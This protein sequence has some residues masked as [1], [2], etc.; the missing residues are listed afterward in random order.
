MQT[1]RMHAKAVFFFFLHFMCFIKTQTDCDKVFI[2]EKITIRTH[3]WKNNETSVTQKKNDFHHTRTIQR[4][5]YNEI[6]LV[7]ITQLILH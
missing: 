6:F 2:D 7:F 3:K 5:D 4:S 1:E